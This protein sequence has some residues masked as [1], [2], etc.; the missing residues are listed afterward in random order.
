MKLLPF[1]LLAVA[2]ALPLRADEAIQNGDFAD[3]TTHWHG[4]GRSS[5]DFASDNPLQASD[6]FTAKGMI[7]P[8]KAN[9]VDEGGADHPSQRHR[10]RA[11]HHIQVLEGTWC[12]RT[13]PITTRTSRSRWGGAGSR[14]AAL[15]EAGLFVSRTRLER[16]A[17][18]PTVKPKTGTSDPQ[19]YR[20]KMDTLT[21]HDETTLTLG[22]PPGTGMVVI[23]GVSFDTK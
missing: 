7:I 3:G 21:P 9:V 17:R 16:R 5:A 10:R 15:P 11:D 4:E 23:L 8:L 14:S 19:T 13:S 22:F 1:L 2:C 12:S 18:T 20:V 6:P